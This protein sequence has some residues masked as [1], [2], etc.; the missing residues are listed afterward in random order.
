MKKA[1]LSLST[2]F[3]AFSVQ[4]GEICYQEVEDFTADEVKQLPG[5]FTKYEGP[6]HI[7]GNDEYYIALNYYH[8]E[9]QH[10]YCKQFGQK[11]HHSE[12]LWSASQGYVIVEN[13]VELNSEGQIID[14]HDTCNAF[15]SIT[16]KPKNLN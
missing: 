6:K 13:C 2:L 10:G 12:R 11:Y 14:V 3:I 8:D 4:A 9:S 5:G 15:S 1:L 7:F 16:C